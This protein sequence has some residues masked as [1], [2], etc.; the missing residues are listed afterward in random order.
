[1]GRVVGDRQC[2]T[3]RA[4]PEAPTGSSHPSLIER[5]KP[6]PTPHRTGTNKAEAEQ[7]ETRW[8]RYFRHLDFFGLENVLKPR[9]GGAAAV[10]R[11]RKHGA[12][13]YPSQVRL[14]VHCEHE[15]A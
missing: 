5:G 14:T 9:G 6:E 2:C 10:Y 15:I 13:A 3:G 11:P 7:P 4:E 8:L 12:V 1:V